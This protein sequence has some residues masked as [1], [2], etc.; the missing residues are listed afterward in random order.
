MHQIALPS[1]RGLLDRECF[2]QKFVKL[3][4]GQHGSNRI[5]LYLKFLNDAQGRNKIKVGFI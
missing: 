1:N 5:V 3:L 2:W 4:Q